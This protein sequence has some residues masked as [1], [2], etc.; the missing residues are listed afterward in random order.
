M[1]SKKTIKADTSGLSLWVPHPKGAYCVARDT[2]KTEGSGAKQM[3]LYETT[4]SKEIVKVLASEVMD[5]VHQVE[6]DHLMGVPDVTSLRTVNNPSVLETCRVR[7]RKDQIYTK[8]DDVVISVNPFKL[9]SGLYDAAQVQKYQNS[10]SARDLPPHV[11]CVSKN[12]LGGLV[13]GKN[14]AILISGESGAGKSE[15]CKILVSYFASTSGG[16]DGIQDRI[17]Q[18]TPLLEAYGNAKTSRN[19]NSSRFGK[20]TA[21]KFSS[22]GKIEGAGVVDYLLEKSR[23]VSQNAPERSFHIFHMMLEDPERYGLA[24]R[25]HTDYEF[26]K[27]GT[28]KAD[29]WDDK[30]ELGEVLQACKD[31]T[32]AESKS[33]DLIKATAGVL[34]IGNIALADGGNDTTKCG[35]PETLQ[36]CADVFG[37]DGDILLSAIVSKKLVIGKDVTVKSLKLADAITARKSLATLFYQRIFDWL[38]LFLNNAIAGEGGLSSTAKEI[39]LLDI[40]GFESFPFNTWEQITINLSNENLQQHFN[41]FIFKSELRDYEAEGVPVDEFNF[42]DNQEIL[43]T[44]GAPQNSIFTYLDGT[45]KNIK[46][47]DEVFMNELKKNMAKNKYLTLDKFNK[48]EFTLKHYAG[49]VKYDV[50]GWVSV[51][52]KD[53]PPPEA[54]DILKTCQNPVMIELYEKMAEEEKARRQTVSQAFR[55]SLK[56]LMTAIY[57]AQ[58]HFVRCIKPNS[59]KVAGSFDPPMVLEQLIFSGVIECVRIRQAGYPFRASP[60]EFIRAYR[61][62]I[63]LSLQKKAMEGGQKLDSPSAVAVVLQGLPT[64][65]KMPD[66]VG[67]YHMGRTKVMVRQ[68]GHMLLDEMSRIA[69]SAKAVMIQKV[70]RGYVVR[71]KVKKAKE[72]R[73]AIAAW[74]KKYPLYTKGGADGMALLG[75]L[76]GISQAISQTVI[77]MQ[78]VNSVPGLRV[79]PKDFAPTI[80]GLQKELDIMQQADEFLISTDVAAL[81]GAH[82]SLTAL[83]I[84]SDFC[85]TIGERA[86]RLQLE[87]PLVKGMQS[88]PPLTFDDGSAHEQYKKLVKS[89]EGAGLTAAEKWLDATGFALYTAVAASLKKYEAGPPTGDTA[90]LDAEKA[91]LAVKNVQEVLES[92]AGVGTQMQEC[93]F[94]LSEDADKQQMEYCGGCIERGRENLESAKGMLDNKESLDPQIVAFLCHAIGAREEMET[95]LNAVIKSASDN[96]D[97]R[98]KLETMRNGVRSEKDKLDA[99]L[100]AICTQSNIDAIKVA[101]I[102][103]EAEKEKA[104]RLM[105]T[106]RQSVKMSPEAAA[107]SLRASKLLGDMSTPQGL[108]L[109][110]RDAADALAQMERAREVFDKEK[111]EALLAYGYENGLAAEDL[112]ASEKLVTNLKTRSYVLEQIEGCVEKLMSGRAGKGD[113]LPMKLL[114]LACTNLVAAAE[115]CGVAAAQTLDVMGTIKTNAAA[116][117]SL[118]VGNQSATSN[119]LGSKL[120]SRWDQAPIMNTVMVKRRYKQD[121]T[122]VDPL[123]PLG[124][125]SWSRTPAALRDPLTQLPNWQMN[126]TAHAVFENIIGWMCDKPVPSKHRA[127]LAAAV[128][129]TAKKD[130]VITNEVYAQLMKQLT[131]N[132]SWQSKSL[133]WRL[134]T[135]VLQAVPPQPNFIEYVRAFLINMRDE[136]KDDAITELINVAK[137]EMRVHDNAMPEGQVMQSMRGFASTNFKIHSLETYDVRA[138]SARID[139]R[140]HPRRAKLVALSGPMMTAKELCMKACHAFSLMSQQ[141]EFSLFNTTSGEP[142]N[143]DANVAGMLNANPDLD[144][145]FRRRFLRPRERVSCSDIVYTCLSAEQALQSYLNEY[146][147]PEEKHKLA[148]IGA[149]IAVYLSRAKGTAAFVN[150]NTLPFLVPDL[151]RNLAE[152]DQKWVDMIMQELVKNKVLENAGKSH[153]ERATI[154]FKSLQRLKAFGARFYYLTQRTHAQL[155]EKKSMDILG[156]VRT[157][158]V[159][160]RKKLLEMGSRTLL[161]AV[162]ISSITFFELDPA[163]KLYGKEMAKIGFSTARGHHLTEWHDFGDCLYLSIRLP[164]AAEV[165]ALF[166][167]SPETAAC[168]CDKLVDRMDRAYSEDYQDEGARAPRPELKSRFVTRTLAQEYLSNDE[169]DTQQSGRAPSKRATEAPLGTIVKE[170]GSHN[171]V[172]FAPEPKFASVKRRSSASVKA[173]IDAHDAAAN[174]VKDIAEDEDHG[175]SFAGIT[176]SSAST[177]GSFAPPPRTSEQAPTAE[178]PA[179]AAAEEAPAASAAEEEPAAP[180]EEEVAAAPAAEEAPAAPAAEEEPLPPVNVVNEEPPSTSKALGSGRGNKNAEETGK[181][182]YNRGDASGQ[183]TDIRSGKFKADDA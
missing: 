109:T 174:L 6:E 163:H 74:L 168:T 68:K 152:S 118:F 55:A 23:A 122:I 144:L 164:S 67:Q 119:E 8:V 134:F 156:Q 143:D 178:E 50:T 57:A 1:A 12:A 80:A 126:E 133:G 107:M 130:P 24:S 43:D 70:Y 138:Q 181:Q 10:E 121:G 128:V 103:G 131:N 114:L 141:S 17:V 147:V 73:G 19:N 64:A 99:A 90:A 158:A 96:A 75:G 150:A 176:A 165:F 16:E 84:T 49:S 98:G 47:T 66:L 160:K 45:T 11:Y 115:G 127:P 167:V 170:D 120:Y 162:T 172:T 89:C 175:E 102:K 62:V 105:E 101:T 32:M 20:W 135:H 71:K 54:L 30:K 116:F 145:I 28:A 171:R 155:G 142:L 149:Q 123:D 179:A 132:P 44:I 86:E 3:K 129:Q 41:D 56:K 117:G 146:C 177:K 60:E 140:G 40:A 180:V 18:C 76:E 108:Q 59:A 104:Q 58:P 63:P 5:K 154:M 53:E 148:W 38:I 36:Q 4:E 14:Q 139:A 92:S 72:T 83:N 35:K 157:H 7:F 159:N 61:V 31:T 37:C 77:W 153:L 136:E 65:F 79:A 112:E 182:M 97:L 124:A 48:P 52:N 2:G 91:A 111:L 82:S 169:P 13:E 137:G 81:K 51:K 183:T 100:S 39:G 33:L 166:D 85:K 161:L 95:R 42:E 15:N 106:E 69:R 9:I 151:C 29:G 93:V 94:Q 87:T 125:C 27:N 25:K 88:L 21:L 26:L 110:I 22:S 46:A 78:V 173:S 113:V 34:L